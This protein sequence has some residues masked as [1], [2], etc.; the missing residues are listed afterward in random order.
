MKYYATPVQGQPGLSVNYG[1]TVYK[2]QSLAKELCDYNI[3]TQIIGNYEIG[4]H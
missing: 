4:G 2:L 1:A 3:V